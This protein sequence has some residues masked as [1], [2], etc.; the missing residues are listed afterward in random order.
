MPS[1][2]AGRCSPGSPGTSSAQ[3]GQAERPLPALM[4]AHPA[5]A[6]ARDRQV[7]TTG[8]T[9]DWRCCCMVALAQ[10]M[11]VH[12]AGP[13]VPHAQHGCGKTL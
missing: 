8:L 2:L 4:S 10:G 9:S 1:A 7:H 5:A 3:L 6:M 13:G 12:G 11:Q